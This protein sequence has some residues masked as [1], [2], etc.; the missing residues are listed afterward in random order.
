MHVVDAHRPTCLPNVLSG[1]LRCMSVR[2]GRVKH[3]SVFPLYISTNERFY[4]KQTI[5]LD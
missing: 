1:H 3:N 4:S 5:I 2:L